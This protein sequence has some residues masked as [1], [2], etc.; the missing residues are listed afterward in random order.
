MWR[1]GADEPPAPSPV[2]APVPERSSE[3]VAPTANAPVVAKKVATPRESTPA[4][5]ATPDEIESPQPPHAPMR[6]FADR[7]RANIGHGGRGVRHPELVERLRQEQELRPRPQYNPYAQ[8]DKS[9]VD[10][11]GYDAF[12]ERSYD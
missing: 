3:E 11:L 8:I 1:T 2:P 4:A 12:G 10:Y 5:L 7:L 9:V 6:T